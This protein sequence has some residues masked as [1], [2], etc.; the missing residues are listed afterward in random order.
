LLTFKR[1]ATVLPELAA[2]GFRKFRNACPET[3][4]EVSKH[5]KHLPDWRRPA[6]GFCANY[7]P[8]RPA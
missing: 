3:V 6:R 4:S 5:A 7:A 1:L 8:I 2:L